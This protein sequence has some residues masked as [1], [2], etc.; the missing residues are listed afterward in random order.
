MNVSSLNDRERK[1]VLD[2]LRMERERI[3]QFSWERIGRVH[4]ITNGGVNLSFNCNCVEGT[5]DLVRL[6]FVFPLRA[7]FN[8]VFGFLKVEKIAALL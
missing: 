6:A 3:L 8:R 1:M 2:R 4:T 7:E 5:Y